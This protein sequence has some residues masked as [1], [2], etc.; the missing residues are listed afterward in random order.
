MADTVLYSRED[1]L[2]TVTV[3]RPDALGALDTATKTAL[4]DAVTE[5]AEDPHVRAVL[6]TGSGR[7]FCVGQD[8]REHAAALRAGATDPLG[9]TIDAHYTP[10]ARTLTT[11]PKPV[12]AA[13]N[14]V[15]AGAGASLAFAC[16]FRVLARSASFTTAFTGIG[17]TADSAM[18]WTLPRLVGTARATELLMLAEPVSADE[19]LRIGLATDVVDNDELD[20][21]A[22]ALASRLAHGPTRA[23]AAVKES[24]RVSAEGSLDDTLHTERRLQSELGATTDHQDAVEAFTAKQ[25]PEFTGR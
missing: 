20:E 16:D 15:A 5:A 21:R 11:M 4:R 2:A 7:A 1:A 19:A 17:L 3:N 23:Y 22:R 8:L 25:T 12:V 6:L 24:L 10:I 14:G 13:V 9:S 18:S